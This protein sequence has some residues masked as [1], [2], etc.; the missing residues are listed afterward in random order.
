MAVWG[1]RVMETALQWKGGGLLAGL[2]VV[3]SSGRGFMARR[4][5]VGEQENTEK[6]EQR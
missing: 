4:S 6:L 1:F 2:R 5:W 3:V